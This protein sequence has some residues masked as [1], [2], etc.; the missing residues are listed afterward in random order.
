MDTRPTP[1]SCDSLGAICVSTRSSTFESGIVFEV[2]A[3]V[4]TGASAGFDFEY[5]GGTGRS[6]GRRLCAAL[7]AACTS[8]S[9]TSMSRLSENCSTIT[10][11]PPAEVEVIWLSPCISPNCRSSGAVTVVEVTSGAA[12]G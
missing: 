10:D 4:S 9:A 8:C 7:I 2:I 1:E 6:D 5:T 11:T 3:I 12:P